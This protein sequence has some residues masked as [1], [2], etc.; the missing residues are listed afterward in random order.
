MNNE[1]YE[2]WVAIL[3]IAFISGALMI[4]IASWFEE[5]IVVFFGAVVLVAF[6]LAVFT[7]MVIGSPL[8]QTEKDFLKNFDLTQV[9]I[10]GEQQFDVSA[11]MIFKDGRLLKIV[12]SQ[13]NK[14]EE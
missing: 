13:P 2:I 3:V 8:T 10:K 7:G 9:K 1:L 5:G 4:A 14:K 12:P 11:K 6:A